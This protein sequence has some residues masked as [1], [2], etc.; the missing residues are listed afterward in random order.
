MK[1][2]EVD[3]NFR[4]WQRDPLAIP[5]NSGEK[6]ELKLYSMYLNPLQSHGNLVKDPLDFFWSS[7]RFYE[8]VTDEFGFLTPHRDQF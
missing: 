8:K 5:L 3:R 1:V 4:I 6:L 7:A 2:D